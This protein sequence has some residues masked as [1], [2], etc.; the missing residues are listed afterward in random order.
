MVGMKLL[1]NGQN[2]EAGMEVETFRKEKGILLYWRE[3]HKPSSSGHVYVLLNGENTER[4]FYPG[5]IG[6]KFR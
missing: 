5:V 1:I 2:A 3:P 6:G 4:E